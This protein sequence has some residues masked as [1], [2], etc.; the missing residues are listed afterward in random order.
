MTKTGHVGQD[1][2]RDCFEMTTFRV[3]SECL[4]LK[5]KKITSEIKK[6]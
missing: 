5:K 6:P 3:I 4:K 2:C 1:P